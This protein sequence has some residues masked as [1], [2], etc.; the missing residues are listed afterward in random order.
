M[1]FMKYG[2]R[3]KERLLLATVLGTTLASDSA[4]AIL[5]HLLSQKLQGIVGQTSRW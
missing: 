1:I 4:S 5:A 2:I 3:T